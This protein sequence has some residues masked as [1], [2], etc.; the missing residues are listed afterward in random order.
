MLWSYETIIASKS[1]LFFPIFIFANLSDYA[2]IN[3]GKRTWES[4]FLHRTAYFYNL[5]YNPTSISGLYNLEYILI[6]HSQTWRNKRNLIF[7]NWWYLLFYDLN[8]NL[9]KPLTT[10]VVLISTLMEEGQILVTETI[11]THNKITE[12]YDNKYE[13]QLIKIT[14]NE[15]F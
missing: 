14:E 7:R 12:F 5:N 1:H 11:W 9:S 13:T 6:K 4:H 8:F 15:K 2:S 3:L 10:L